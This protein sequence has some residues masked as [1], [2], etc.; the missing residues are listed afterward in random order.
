MIFILQVWEA[1]D[2]ESRIHII[3]IFLIQFFSEQLHRFA[4]SLEVNDLT[5]SQETDN[6]IY[7]RVIR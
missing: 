2:I 5:F 6:I 1:S 3:H 4:K 7:I